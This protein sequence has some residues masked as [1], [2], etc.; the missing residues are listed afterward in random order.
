MNLAGQFAKRIRQWCRLSI[1]REGA[2][3]VF[4]VMA[5]ASLLLFSSVLIDYARLAT[6]N[7]MTEDA[8]R[9][10]TRSVLSAFDDGLYERYGLFGRGGT[11]GEELF[12]RSAQAN[13]ERQRSLTGRSFRMV[14]AK[15][16]DVKLNDAAYLGS[17][18]IFKRQVLEEMKY[19]APIDFTIDLLSK[20]APLSETLKEGTAA[21]DTLERLRKLYEKRQSLLETIVSLQEEAAEEAEKGGLPGL[22][23]VD[24][25]KAA[26]LNAN[27][28]AEDYEL[29]ASW[30]RTDMELIKNGKKPKYAAQRQAYEQNARTLLDR[31]QKEDGKLAKLHD[32]L[33]L[34]AITALAEAQSVNDEM[35]A[36]AELAEQSPSKAG[37]DRVSEHSSTQESGD[38]DNS[39]ADRQLADIRRTAR[40]VILPDGWFSEYREELMQQSK[41]YDKISLSISNFASTLQAAL[42]TG[43]SYSSVLKGQVRQMQEKYVEYK[44]VYFGERSLIELRR[45]T[46]DQGDVRKRLREQNNKAGSLWKQGRKMLSGLEQPGEG[47]NRETFELVKQ[48]Y[49]HNRLFNEVAAGEED[50]SGDGKPLKDAYDQAEASVDRMD[51]LFAGMADM[52]ERAR[53]SVYAGEYVL[54]RFHAFQPE[55]LKESFTGGD[56]GQGALSSRM[57]FQFQ[58]AE[59]ILY[60]FHRPLANVAASYG[61]LFGVRMAIRT[62][63][64][65]IECRSAGHPLLILGCAV[66]YG[67][68]KTIEDFIGLATNGKAPLSKYAKIDLT[69]SDYLRLFMLLHGGAD[70]PPRLSRMIAVIEQNNGVTLAG[71]PA[72]VSGEV[73]AEMAFWFLPGVMKAIGAFGAW[74]G[75]VNGNRY[76]ATKTMGWSY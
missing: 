56:R 24:G 40:E 51:G 76:E 2:V 74:E 45:E 49:E 25:S 46:V 34:K 20:F 19:K 54:Q 18:P 28:M 22:I 72:A 61:E 58:E 43:Y 52:L 57:D 10:G 12:R 4:S 5:L 11:D 48:R 42:G 44:K 29:Y 16:T 27:A 9:A 69:Y 38:F 33:R 73:K 53:D 47:G 50:F 6:L 14:D 39:G 32:A 62:T 8:A 13:L 21:I 70:S 35:K 31:L 3:T 1:R 55:Y 63:E 41:A 66:I 60:G 36:V 68:E 71:V 67:L 30:V 23:P 37:Y 26:Q 59:Y 17:H 64:G 65:L 15:L 7:K 75:A